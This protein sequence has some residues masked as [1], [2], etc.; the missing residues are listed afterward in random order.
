MSGAQCRS[1]IIEEMFDP[2]FI[3]GAKYLY[4][5]IVALAGLVFLTFP[6]V[7]KKRIVILAAISL[8]LVYILAKVGSHF[9]FDPR[10]FVVGHFTPLVSH[11]ADNGFPSDHVLLTSAVA[12][13]FY[14]FSRKTSYLLFFLAGIVAVSRVYVGVHHTVDVLGSF[15]F[16][17]SVIFFVYLVIKYV[18][19]TRTKNDCTKES[20]ATSIEK[21]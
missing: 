5:V 18:R 1:V 21:E 16:S 15:A 7:D 13:L 2:F 17:L 8:P 20:V 19:R 9:Y 3:F 6:L 11:S 4:M 12:A 14:P 10:P